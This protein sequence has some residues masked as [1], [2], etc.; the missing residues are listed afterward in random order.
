MHEYEAPLKPELAE[1]IKVKSETPSIKTFD[2]RFVDKKLQKQFAFLPGKFVMVSVFGYGEMPISISSSPFEKEFIQLTV[3]A[4]G[5][6]SNAMHRL[7]KGDLIGLRGPFG[8]G[9]LLQRFRR[10]NI[11][12]FSGGCGLA[13]IRSAVL[14]ALAKKDMFG[15]IFLFHGCKSS[16]E[17]LFGKEIANWERRNS[18]NA[19]VSVDIPEKGWKG[20]TGFVTDLIEKKPLPV[21]NTVV[22]MCGPPVMVKIAIQKF[23]DLGFKPEQIYASLERLMHCGVGKCGHCNIGREYVCVHGPV[24]SGSQIEKMHLEEG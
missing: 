24:F 20:H 16:K 7:K 6:I 11:V 12:F 22:L 17:L 21:E 19:C 23:K 13:S 8:R 4:V 1:I 3:N 18:L 10:K 9:Y 5:N 2:V 14:A 15:D